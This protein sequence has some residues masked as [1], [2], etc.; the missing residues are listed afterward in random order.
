[1]EPS[2]DT[3]VREVWLIAVTLLAVCLFAL[4]AMAPAALPLS[5]LAWRSL[6]MSVKL[7]LQALGGVL[8]IAAARR[9][10]VAVHIRRAWLGLAAGSFA[11]LLGQLVLADYQL[12]RGVDVP[13][14]SPAEAFFLLAYPFLV[15]S[16][17]GFVRAFREAGWPFGGPNEDQRRMLMVAGFALIA[18]LPALQPIALSAGP[19]LDRA[20]SVA[21]PLLD[22]VLLAPAVLLARVALGP[23]G[24][25]TRRVW[26]A[27]VA[28]VVGL[29]LGDV[30]FAYQTSLDLAAL[31]PVVDLLYLLA[32]GAFALAPLYQIGLTGRRVPA[33]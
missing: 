33:N 32:Y 19:L 4:R 23:R 26:L 25:R 21:Y 3:R 31:D 5:E 10:P 30:L 29:V 22:I 16:Q 9:F 8:A 15:A 13:F 14:P 7:L 24:G 1:M 11:F 27:L 20:I 28:G 12:R 18:V 6:A 2:A 17:L